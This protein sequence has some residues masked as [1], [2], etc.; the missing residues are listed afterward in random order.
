MNG[1]GARGQSNRTH[2]DSAHEPQDAN[3]RCTLDQKNGIL[4]A[5][6]HTGLDAAA[7]FCRKNGFHFPL[8]GLLP[9]RPLA[10]V[11]RDWV[12]FTDAFV[13]NLCGGDNDSK[14]LTG[15]SAPRAAV[16]PDLVG[17]IL[18]PLG[19][20][21]AQRMRIRVFAE[22]AVQEVWHHADRHAHVVEFIQEEMR[23]GS[24]FAIQ[25][26][27]TRIRYLRGKR[28]QRAVDETLA[29]MEATM[30]PIEL[31]HIRSGQLLNWADGGQLR[32]QLEAG[33]VILAAPFMGRLGRLSSDVAIEKSPN[34]YDE[35]SRMRSALIANADGEPSHG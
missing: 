7:Q 20:T 25:A 29:G 18:S 1:I 3:A 8:A 30:K 17:A 27:G 9:Q 2:P 23:I 4:L 14:S 34:T 15:V 26:Y 32:S 6:A 19:K 13:V 31:E 10:Q 33:H 5:S 22:T 35:L 16:G 12:P 28:F 11:C 24:G 21:D